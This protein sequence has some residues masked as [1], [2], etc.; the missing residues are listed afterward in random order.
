MLC[1]YVCMLMIFFPS[2]VVVTLRWTASNWWDTLSRRSPVPGWLSPSC[3]TE[4]Y[5]SNTWNPKM[6][7][8][9]RWCSFSILGDFQVPFAVQ[10]S[11]GVSFSEPSSSLNRHFHWMIFKVYHS[12]ASLGCCFETWCLVFFYGRSCFSALREAMR[13][14]GEL[15]KGVWAGC[16]KAL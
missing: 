9:F 16:R 2:G 12:T 10:F 1:V 4:V 14:Y 7:V 11:R 8:W 5:L 15:R 3:S 6:E 13:G